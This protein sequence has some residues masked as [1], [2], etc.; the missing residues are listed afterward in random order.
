MPGRK[1][2]PTSPTLP[3]IAEWVG[4][5]NDE[6]YTPPHIF[7][8]LDLYFDLDPCS[9]PGG[10]PWIPARHHLTRAED[11][12]TS[13]WRG[14]VWL[15]P[16]YS[17]PAPWVEKLSNH[18]Q[19]VALLPVDTSTESWHTR[20]SIADAFCFLR[21]RLRFVAGANTRPGQATG[22]TAR[23]PTAL[24]AWGDE[25]ADAAMQCGLGWCVDQR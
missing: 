25:A 19:G 21:G 3:G 12:L 4:S 2:L 23:F 7:D 20:I 13:P 24:V 17:I 15:N 22:W 6:W 16:P 1:P 14:L 5:E 11:G 8:A 9:P 10:L 18:G